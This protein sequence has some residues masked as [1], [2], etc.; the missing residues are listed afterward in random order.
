[1]AYDM[2]P[3]ARLN[4][5]ICEKSIIPAFLFFTNALHISYNNTS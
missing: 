5:S 3:F 1:M 2:R 4:N